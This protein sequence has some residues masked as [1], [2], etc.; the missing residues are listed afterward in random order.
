MVMGHSEIWARNKKTANSGVFTTTLKIIIIVQDGWLSMIKVSILIVRLKLL[1]WLLTVQKN[2]Y[3]DIA[4]LWARSILILGHQ[5][6]W[7]ALNPDEEVCFQ[8]KRFLVTGG[9][10]VAEALTQW[11]CSTSPPPFSPLFGNYKY[12]L[13][14]WAI[15]KAQPWKEGLIIIEFTFPSLSQSF[16]M[17][18]SAIPVT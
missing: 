16:N 10:V 14:N 1:H 7:P 17:Y 13:Q 18:T 15:L 12:N 8:G 11:S 2:W 9:L 3:D 4:F 5:N 6:N